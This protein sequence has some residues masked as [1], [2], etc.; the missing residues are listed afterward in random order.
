MAAS[1]VIYGAALKGAELALK[2]AEKFANNAFND[3]KNAISKALYPGEYRHKTRNAS[4]KAAMNSLL[5]KAV[6]SAK[7]GDYV[8][9]WAIA[10]T[11]ATL[12][13]RSPYKDWL[14]QISGAVQQLSAE[15][16][17]LVEAYGIKGELQANKGEGG[18]FVK[19]GIPWLPISIGALALVFLMRGKSNGRG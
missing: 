18:T 9:A 11:A 7:A 10:K 13:T 15:A 6:A 3:I 8:T 12:S 1:T 4:Y 19:A 5:N 16:N 14:G 2:E 17:A